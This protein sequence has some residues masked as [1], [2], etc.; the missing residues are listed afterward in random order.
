[1]IWL[2]VKKYW[3]P[4]AIALL[5]LAIAGTGYY[6][7]SIF[8]ENEALKI[9]IKDKEKQINDIRQLVSNLKESV[10]EQEENLEDLNLRLTD[11]QVEAKEAVQI[12][13]KHNLSDLSAK[14]PGLIEKRV[15]KATQNVFLVL[16]QD[17]Q[18][19]YSEVTNNE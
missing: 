3:Q 7:K 16:Q 15:N 9:D 19:F 10:A 11:I 18:S 2:L 5:V 6:I 1:M 13:A 12:F 8:A 17:T 14:K 4:L